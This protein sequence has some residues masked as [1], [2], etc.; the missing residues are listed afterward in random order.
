MGILLQ[1]FYLFQVSCF[2][3]YLQAKQRNTLLLLHTYRLTN[4]WHLSVIKRIITIVKGHVSA[5][6]RDLNELTSV[7]I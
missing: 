5:S 4:S 3:E 7:N 2:L 1:S 6:R